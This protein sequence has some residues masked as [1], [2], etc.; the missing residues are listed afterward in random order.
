MVMNKDPRKWLIA[1]AIA[2]IF[3]A[4]FPA[5]Y[6][7]SDSKPIISQVN[8]VSLIK[9][10]DPSVVYIEAVDEYG[11]YMWSGSGVIICPD[12]LILTAG[13]VIDGVEAFKIVLF[14]GRE[15]WSNKSYLSDVTDIGLIKIDAERLS[16][17]YLGNSDNLRKGGEVFIIGCP[18]GIGL[19]NTVTTGIISGLGRNSGGFFGE[20][21]II[22]SDSQSWPGNSGGPVY[23]MQGRVIGILVGG[24]WGVDGISLIIP[25]NICKLVLNI[26]KAEKELERCH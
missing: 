2:V 14:D 15:F 7:R 3:A 17:S 12:G 6:Y 20:K 19:R 11:I 25:S 4:C 18:F 10:V 23:N 22:Q 8:L 1:I 13:H 24:Y 9:R 21:L 26:Y 16:F 5:V